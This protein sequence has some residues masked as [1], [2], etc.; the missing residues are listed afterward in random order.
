MKLKCNYRKI[1]NLYYLNNNIFNKSKSYLNQQ[2][3]LDFPF[4]KDD[5][6]LKDKF[7]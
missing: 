4:L 5:N 1:S 3:F 2:R 6:Y 7:V